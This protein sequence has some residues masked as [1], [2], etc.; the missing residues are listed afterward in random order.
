MEA[1]AKDPRMADVSS[2]PL[3]QI[4]P[5]NPSLF[6]DD[7]IGGY[8]DRLRKE[9]PIFYRKGGYSGDFW[10]VTVDASSKL[11]QVSR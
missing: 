3:A 6:A 9:A 5:S 1:I 2:V 10:S 4:D 8:F 11:S 7:T